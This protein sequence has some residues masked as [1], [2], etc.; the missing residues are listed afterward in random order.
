MGVAVLAFLLDGFA[1]WARSLRAPAES[2]SYLRV[3][4]AYTFLATV[5]IGNLWLIVLTQADGERPVLLPPWIAGMMLLI[6]A[7]STLWLCAELAQS[8]RTMMRAKRVAHP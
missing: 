3:G 6:A 5:T 7:A 4:S 8:L 2:R 1:L